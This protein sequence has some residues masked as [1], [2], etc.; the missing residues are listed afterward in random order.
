MPLKQVRY[1]FF[2]ETPRKRLS[3]IFNA[4]IQLPVTRDGPNLEALRQGN[5]FTR[6]GKQRVN[7]TSSYATVSELKRFLVR[8]EQ[9]KL[10][11]E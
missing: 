1:L 5:F 8:T 7:G 11:D 6:G 10:V 9:G 3:D 4:A 2:E